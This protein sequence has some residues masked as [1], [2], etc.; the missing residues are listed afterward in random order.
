[1]NPASRASAP[2]PPTANSKSHRTRESRTAAVAAAA[3][4]VEHVLQA[5]SLYRPVQAVFQKVQQRMSSLP[6]ATAER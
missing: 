5:T 6:S 2:A 4:H 1:M 3:D